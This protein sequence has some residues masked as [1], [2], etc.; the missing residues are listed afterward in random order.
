MRYPRRSILILLSC[1]LPYCA[2][3]QEA[4]TAPAAAA[5]DLTLHNGDPAGTTVCT[6]SMDGLLRY[7]GK[8]LGFERGMVQVE[9][10]S[11]TSK[12]DGKLTPDFHVT[13]VWDQPAH[14]TLCD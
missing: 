1:L 13:K 10:S 8:V 4:A 12:A 14:W 5:K 3:A 9:V 2:W 6:E 7:R 11:A